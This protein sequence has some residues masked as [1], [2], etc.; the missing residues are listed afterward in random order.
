MFGA[1]PENAFQGTGA[2]KG[3]E[4]LEEIK[5]IK[6]DSK[7]LREF[8]YLV[9]GIL[10]LLGGLFFW[11]GHSYYVYF[12]AIGVALVILGFCVPKIL[13]SL[14][15]VWMILALMIGWVMTRIL[16][17]FLF[18]LVVTPIHW[19]SI[20]KGNPCLDTRFPD[21]KESY[22]IKRNPKKEKSSYE[23]QF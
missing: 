22:W 16:L 12:L 6:S 5:K 14:Y 17:G 18:Y 7:T 1:L 8:G 23:K 4:M 13:K 3:P 20:L 9:G 2:E 10:A 19:I 11:R 15:K 21:E